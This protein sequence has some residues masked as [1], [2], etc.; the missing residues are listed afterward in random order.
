MI[1]VRQTSFPI[2]VWYSGPKFDSFLGSVPSSQR[3][4]VIKATVSDSDIAE[5]K[6]LKSMKVIGLDIMV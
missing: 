6:R 5:L 3:M 1:R 2:P 4:I